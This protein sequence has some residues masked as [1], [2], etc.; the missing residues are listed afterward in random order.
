MSGEGEWEPYSAHFA[1]TETA[2]KSHLTEHPLYRPP[3][4]ASYNA[5]GNIIDGRFIGAVTHHATMVANSSV[6][7]TNHMDYLVGTIPFDTTTAGD[8]SIGATSSQTHR[9]T[10]DATE[11][12]RRWGTSLSTAET[13]LKVTLLHNMDTG[14]C[15]DCLI[16][17]LGHVRT[18]YD[19][20]Y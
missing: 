6:F 2:A 17:N 16:D 3:T 19:E 10:V 13:T 18:N 15:M 7:Y 8:H 14:T 12:A 4:Q 1:A 20:T 11:L 9:S 5:E